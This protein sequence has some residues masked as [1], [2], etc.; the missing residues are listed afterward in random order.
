M[1]F[2]LSVLRAK[3]LRTELFGVTHV[4]TVLFVH[5]IMKMTKRRYTPGPLHTFVPLHESWVCNCPGRKELERDETYLITGFMEHLRD[6][7]KMVID[8]R[9]IVRRWHETILVDMLANKE[10]YHG[11]SLTP[12]LSNY[13]KFFLPTKDHHYYDRFD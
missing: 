4:R 7:Y 10:E 2:S 11:L 9:S 3:L 1:Y 6:G 5:V 13:K 12:S 8:H